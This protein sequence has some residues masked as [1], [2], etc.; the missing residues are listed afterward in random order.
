MV[1]ITNLKN[2]VQKMKRAGHIIDS[3]FDI[4]ANKGKW[5]EEWLLVCPSATFSLFEA[6]PYH[7][8]PDNLDVKHKWFNIVL[9]KPGIDNVEFYSINNTGDSYYKEN[10]THYNQSVKLNLKANTL[11][12]I[13]NTFNLIPPQLIKLDT[14]GSEVDI[15]LGAE[16]TLKTA[17]IVVCEMPILEYNIGAPMF[18]DYLTIFKSLDFIPVCIDQEHFSKGSLL[19]ID[20][21]F[22]KSSKVHMIC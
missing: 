21:V 16:H 2:I 10:T 5:T 22:L 13:V 8:R 12:K 15:L 7:Y 20:M 9:S 17:D 18:N 3:V 4:G 1:T 6:N 19:Q 11:D 14:Q